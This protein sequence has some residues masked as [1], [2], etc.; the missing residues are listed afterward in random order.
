LEINDHPSLNISLCKEGA[1]GLLKSPSEVDKHIKST[2]LGDAIKLMKKF[3]AKDRNSLKK[4]KTWQQILPSEDMSN[5]TSL[6]KAK[7]IFD[8]LSSTSRQDQEA[9]KMGMSSFCKI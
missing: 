2:V 5:I 9:G 7:Q 8:F 4:F 6:M 3:P 1:K